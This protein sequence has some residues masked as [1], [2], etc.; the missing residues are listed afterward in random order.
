MDRNLRDLA[1]VIL[2]F[3]EFWLGRLFDC[4]GK[5]DGRRK[6]TKWRR[7]LSIV[8]TCLLIEN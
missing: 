7:S 8:L 6:Y 2:V 5:F 1:L 3:R 4:L